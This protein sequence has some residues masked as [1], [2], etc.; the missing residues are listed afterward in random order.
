[1]PCLLFKLYDKIAFA[2]DIY[3]FGQAFFKLKGKS[4][5]LLIDPFDPNV[6]NLK[7]P[8]PSELEADACLVTHS[9]P[10]HSNTKDLPGVSL[11]IEGSGEYETKGVAISG[12]STFHDKVK[13]QDRGKN[14]V[15]HIEM[16]GLNLVH[17]GDLGH[18]LSDEKVSEIGECDIL[19]VPVGGVYTIE[20]KEAAEVVAQLEPKVIVPMH[21][22]LPGLKAPLEGVEKFLKEMGEEGL[23]AQNKLTVSK[24]KLPEEPT[25]VL[26][27]K[28]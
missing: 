27:N 19:M 14:I 11:V 20:S 3:W 15:Y 25:V 10:D 6:T 1:M 12:V 28:M 16:D 21:Y 22:L 4:A 2:M 5:A 13:G 9:H 7:F 23:T 24:D 17:L 8:K 26:L 18:T